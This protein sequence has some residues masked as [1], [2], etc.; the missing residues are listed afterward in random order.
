ENLYIEAISTSM[1]YWEVD[2]ADAD[3]FIAA[4]PYDA[5]NWKSSLGYAA[6]IG[7]Y[8]RGIEAWYF[9]RR[10]DFPTLTVPGV[11]DGLV[12]RMPYSNDE[13]NQNGT[14]VEAAAS[15]IGGDEYTTK[16]F[17]DAN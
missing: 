6:W 2:A 11:A 1:E 3:A 8:N 15:A 10:L 9:F 12:Y 14:N 4:H 7:M 13:Y 17:W 5:A 16:L